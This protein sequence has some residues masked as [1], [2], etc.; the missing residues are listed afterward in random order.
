VWVKAHRLSWEI[1]N[2]PI[3]EGGVICHHCD[4]PP[5]VNPAH[6]FMGTQKDNIA[7]RQGKGRSRG[8]TDGNGLDY[9]GTANPNV[10]LSEEDVRAIEMAVRAGK[11][12][13]DVAAWFGVSHA[14]VSNIFR[15][16]SWKHLWQE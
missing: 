13:E 7:D 15:H 16:R 9:R 5:C 12:Q 3:P 2:G 1:H 8:G 11:R 4:N 14:T 6:L 10:K